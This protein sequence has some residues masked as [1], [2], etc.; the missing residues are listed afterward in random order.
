MIRNVTFRATAR[1]SI[2]MP[3]K[4]KAITDFF[5]A[6]ASKRTS[7]ASVDETRPVKKVTPWF[8]VHSCILHVRWSPIIPL[9]QQSNCPSSFSCTHK[10]QPIC[11]SPQLVFVFPSLSDQQFQHLTV[12]LISQLSATYQPLTEAFR[13]RQ[14]MSWPCDFVETLH[15]KRSLSACPPLSDMTL[16]NL[17][18]ENIVPKLI[19]WGSIVSPWF[20][21]LNFWSALAHASASGNI[22]WAIIFLCLMWTRGFFDCALQGIPALPTPDMSG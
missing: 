3:D 15:S 2:A 13:L 7:G 5:S 21:S 17:E 8:F 20:L 1:L 18:H 16:Q 19:T 9:P 14:H 10:D 11:I 12:D 4:P 6:K 22:C